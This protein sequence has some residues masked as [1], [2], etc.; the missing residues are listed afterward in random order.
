MKHRCA[1]VCVDLAFIRGLVLQRYG[2]R[3]KPSQWQLG[4]ASG[5]DERNGGES[6]RIAASGPGKSP[7]LVRNR[8]FGGNNH[9]RSWFGGLGV[10]CLGI[11]DCARA[12]AQQWVERQVA[13]SIC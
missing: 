4:R 2:R 6:L 11:L 1:H 12:A 9:C 8:E 3:A 13:K 10:W 7:Q 5:Y